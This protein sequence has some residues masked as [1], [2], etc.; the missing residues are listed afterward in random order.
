[1]T[2]HT[3]SDEQAAPETALGQDKAA[4]ASN[5]PMALASVGVC[6]GIAAAFAL[7]AILA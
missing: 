4:S 3:G 5:R 6:L 2:E 1:M 7:V